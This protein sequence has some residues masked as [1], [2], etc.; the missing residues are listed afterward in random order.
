MLIVPCGIKLAKSITHASE[1]MNFNLSHLMIGV[2]LAP[3]EVP[4]LLDPAR[5]LCEHR[6][7]HISGSCS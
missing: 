7:I 6:K 1:L 3:T 2:S 5:D 4:P